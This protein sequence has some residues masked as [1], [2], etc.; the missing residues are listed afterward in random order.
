MLR[1]NFNAIDPTATFH[2]FAA[3]QERHGWIVLVRMQFRLFTGWPAL[4][5]K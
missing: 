1:L 4:G 2:I 3:V 5:V